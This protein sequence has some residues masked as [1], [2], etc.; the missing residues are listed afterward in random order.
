MRVCDAMP[1]LR[2]ACA[3]TVWHRV[4]LCCQRG[5]PRVHEPT[6]NVYFMNSNCSPYTPVQFTCRLE[7]LAP[8]TFITATDFGG[9]QLIS[10]GAT[11]RVG[12]RT[13]ALTTGCCCELL[14]RAAACVV[15]PSHRARARRHT[16]LPHSEICAVPTCSCFFCIVVHATSIA[17]LTV[18]PPTLADVHWR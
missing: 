11:T 3:S 15:F 1:H 8:S 14:L 10:G 12:V 16:T 7:Q 5:L 2:S 9:K 17:S 13:R 4:E 18:F 6:A